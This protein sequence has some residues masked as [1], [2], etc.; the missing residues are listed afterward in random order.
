MTIETFDVGIVKT[1]LMVTCVAAGANLRLLRKWA[2]RAGDHT[3]PLAG[4]WA[5]SGRPASRPGQREVPAIWP[6]GQ[7]HGEFRT[8]TAP[9]FVRIPWLAWGAP[10]E[11]P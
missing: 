9:S 11:S 10:D 6:G 5:R 7:D 8:S 1:S 2:G 4:A 3:D